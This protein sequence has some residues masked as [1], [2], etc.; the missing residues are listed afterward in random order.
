MVILFVFVCS[1]IIHSS[2]SSDDLYQKLTNKPRFEANFRQ[3]GARQ[4]GVFHYAGLVEY[5]TDGFVEKNKDELPREATDLLLSSSS[6][7][8][9]EL[10][11]II[12]SSSA[13]EPAKTARAGGKK[14]S[15]TVGGHFASVSAI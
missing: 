12:S 7:F 4:F 11:A 14:K 1:R 3:V 9:K 15:V 5:D 13:P 6:A 8:V 10:A 2:V